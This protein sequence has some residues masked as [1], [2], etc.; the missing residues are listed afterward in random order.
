MMLWVTQLLSAYNLSGH[1][2]PFN[3]VIVM[4]LQVGSNPITL[5]DGSPSWNRSAED[6]L[7]RWNPLLGSGVQFGVGTANPPIVDG[8][9]KN[10][11]FFSN[12]FFGQ[13]WGSDVLA[14]TRGHW[15]TS[16]NILVEADVGF[17]NT[18]SWNSY[19][20]PLQTA[21]GG[22]TLHDFHRVAIHEFGHVLGLNHSGV[23]T[24]IMYPTESNTDAIQSDDTAG[25]Q[26][27]YGGG[28]NPTIAQ[29]FPL[30]SSVGGGWYYDNQI[31]YIYPY[32][33]GICYFNTYGRYYYPGD[34]SFTY[35]NGV[36]IY[37][38]YYSSWTYTS[39]SVWPYVYYFNGAYWYGNSF[40]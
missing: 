40:Y 11:V 3:Q 33:N 28:V 4:Y 34:G 37:D 13:A 36:Y 14:T 15:N 9:N 12:T 22:G 29:Y 1:R 26:A 25:V 19:R 27:I 17:N 10:S 35:S 23:T 8:D 2:W 5:I 21:A 30:A 24:A 38:F 20:G 16:T 31:G 6:G 32:S 39:K 7:A 18:K